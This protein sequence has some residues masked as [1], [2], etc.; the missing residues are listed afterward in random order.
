MTNQQFRWGI[1]ATGS[2]AT[3]FAGDLT[4]SRHGVLAGVAARDRQKAADFCAKHGGT[5]SDDLAALLARD[6]IDAVYIATPHNA[7]APMP[8]ARWQPVSRFC[9]KSPWG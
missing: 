1:W 3:T 2:I 7:Q 4:Q 6:D 8:I 9:A 5:P